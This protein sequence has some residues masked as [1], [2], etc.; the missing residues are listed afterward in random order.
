MCRADREARVDRVA[1]QSET[2]LRRG[3]ARVEPQGHARDLE[4]RQRDSTDRCTTRIDRN[5]AHV[6]EQCANGELWSAG[7][8]GRGPAVQRRFARQAN[9]PAGVLLRLVGRRM[10]QERQLGAPE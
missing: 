1:V 7:P 4:R 9:Q 5:V 10:Q 8:E 2:E 6:I 3:R